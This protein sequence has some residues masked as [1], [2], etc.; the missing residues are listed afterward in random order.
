METS[1]RELTVR[2]VLTGIVLG[3]VFGAANAYIGLKVGLTVS[4]SVP[5]AVM[6]VGA[7]SAL[8][9]GRSTILEANLSQ[10]IGS[11]SSSLASGLIF[12][13]PAL[14]LWGRD[15]ELL[16]L[17]VLGATGGLLGVLIMVPLRKAL[18]VEAHD[19]L[20]YPEGTACANVLT[21]AE[22][23][24]AS[25]RPVFIGLG[26]GALFKGLTSFGRLWPGE[27]SAR[28]PRTE[29][30]LE[31][32][33]ALLGVGY[34]LGPRIGALMVAG[35][36]VSWLVLIPAFSA[37]GE[38][39][40]SPLFGTTPVGIGQLEPYAIWTR[41]IRYVGAGAVALA[42]IVT[43]V[44]TTPV[45]WRSLRAGLAA[46]AQKTSDDDNSAPRTE[47]EL[48]MR[49]VVPLVGLT[50]AVVAFTPQ[51]LGIGAPLPFRIFGALA[52]G[53]FAFLFVTV[54][55][56][57]VGLVGV[58]S[59]P[60]SGM[61]IVTL[62]G[63]SLIFYAFGWTDMV[64][65]TTALTIGTVVCVA[66]SMAGDVS[67]DLK[68]GY[69]VGA[70]PRTQQ[71]GELIGILTAVT[72]VAGAIILLA[73]SNTFGSRE[74][75][76]P[77]GTLMQTIVEGVLE[78]KV[79]W[80]L[81]LLGAALASIAVV[82]RVPP[83]AVAVGLYLPLAS[84]TPILLGGIIAWAVRA[85]APTKNGD[86]QEGRPAPDDLGAD[87]G[88]LAASG[89]VAGVGLL[90][91]ALSLYGFLAEQKPPGFGLALPSIVGLALFIGLGA[92]LYRVGRTDQT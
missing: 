59:N 71:L 4:T 36:A 18:I 35:A 26:L 66:A 46:L 70:T 69:L 43:I 88:I 2:A 42:G 67:Q 22:S 27:V 49:I 72:F 5:V 76:A 12:T 73:K 63:T 21:A 57:I 20:P 28:L 8:G 10:T 31:L 68:T 65:K 3:I 82:V 89:L 7:F 34:I 56:R 40:L 90:G 52:V 53:I 84:M 15:P 13:T 81:V 41:Y 29:A 23:G 14:F 54:S 87:A 86:S 79:P 62:L 6:T 1:P 19:E 44:Q 39:T 83:L 60:T 58:S 55:S 91:V 45:M 92:Y 77:Q 51:V 33:P 75:P 78:A 38:T 64:G 61:T 85:N 74:L 25:A 30:G 16:Q 37:Y 80:G 48:S 24:G 47:R 17:I 32:S 11:A 9:R 50:L